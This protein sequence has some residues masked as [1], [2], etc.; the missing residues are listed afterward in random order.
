MSTPITP[1][2]EDPDIT[3]RRKAQSDATNPGNVVRSQDNEVSGEE[4]YAKGNSPS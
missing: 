3:L 4:Q 2:Q 1:D